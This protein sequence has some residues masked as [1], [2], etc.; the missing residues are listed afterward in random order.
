MR[1]TRKGTVGSNP[2]LSAIKTGP[3]TGPFLVAEERA[4]REPGF[5]KTRQ[6]FGAGG[7]AARSE[8]QRP[9]DE[10]RPMPVFTNPTLS[11]T[12]RPWL[13][14]AGHPFSLTRPGS[15]GQGI[16]PRK[17]ASPCSARDGIESPGRRAVFQIRLRD[18]RS[19]KTTS[20]RPMPVFISP[21]KRLSFECLQFVACEFHIV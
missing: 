10:N 6:R 8:G 21:L 18:G 15:I 16:L 9:E 17:T 2:T 1:R 20:L 19:E 14:A 12:H 5:D 11:A 4:R 13:L 3:L 7:I